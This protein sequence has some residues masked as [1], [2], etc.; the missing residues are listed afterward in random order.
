MNSKT[1]IAGLLSASLLTFSSPFA[2][3]ADIST[4]NSANG[5]V[6]I[7]AVPISAEIATDVPI[8]IEIEDM[9]KFVFGSFTGTVVSIS[10]SE[11]VKGMKYYAVENEE[12]AP[13]TIVVTSDT[14]IL[15]NEEISVGSKITGYYN[16]NAP[17]I[18]I[19]PPQYSTEVVV[20][21]REDRNVKVDLFDTDYVSSDN[22]LKLNISVD[23]VIV[24]ENGE[25]FTGELADRKLV[26]VYGPSTRS[27][28]AQTTPE[29]IVVLDE[30]VIEDAD[31]QED[32][33]QV[34]P[35]DVS[36]EKIL[37]KDQPV[38]SHYAYVSAYINAQGI[39]MVPLRAI[40]ESLGHEVAWDNDL[41]RVT[42]D[43]D[44]SFIIGTDSFA[45]GE[46]TIE[47]GTAPEIS[48]DRTFVPLSF[49]QQVIGTDVA[50]VIDGQI[51][52]K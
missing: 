1:I 4:L 34:A 48:Q 11:H 31:N 10:E 36:N 41:K 20:V 13:A 14:Y 25:V 42:I 26:V 52:V 44:I 22:S 45:K 9:N 6:P 49:F 18:M 23:T 8:S 16:A 24:S 51:I 46:K 50:D 32:V 30:D 40:A 47:L 43:S 5:E 27:I 2:F 28:P 21:E 38:S 17:M 15:D 39:V 37:V 19:Y 29:K 35:I 7:S 3:A 12:K 33:S